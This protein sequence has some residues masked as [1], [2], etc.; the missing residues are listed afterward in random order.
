MRRYKSAR[1]RCCNQNPED[2]QVGARASAF[3][4]KLV[5]TLP[6]SASDSTKK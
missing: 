2:G 6:I 1:K 4:G 5:G 3:A